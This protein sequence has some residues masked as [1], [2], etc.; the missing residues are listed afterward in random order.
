MKKSIHDINQKIKKGEATIL[1]AEEVTHLVMDGEEPTVE[2]VDVVTTGTCGIMSGTAAIFHLPVAEPGSFKKAR[3]IT[4]NGVSGFPGPCPNEWLGSVDLMVYGT[5]HSITDPQYGGGFLFKDLLHGEEIEIEVE[6]IDGNILKSSATLEDFGTAQM[7]G[8]RFAFKNYTAFI[9]PTSQPVSSI[10]NA[11]DMDGP[12]KGI[13]FSGC[14]ELNP[15]QNDPQLN[16]I[17][18]GTRLLINN[19]EGLFI[20]PGTRSSPEKPNMMITADMKDMDPHYLGGFRTGAGPEVYN[21]VATAIPILDDEIL[22]KTFI[23]NEDI[24]LPVADIRGRHS[25][26]SQT[27]YEVWRNVDE[28]PTYEKELCQNCQICL[29]EERCPTKA[30]QNHDLNQVRCFG[31]G[32]CAYSCP[33][34]TFQMERGHVLMDWEGEIKELEVSCRQSDIKRARELARELK[35]RIERGEFLLNNL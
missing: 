19:S 16:S 29:V 1:T 13:S 31:C 6:D 18:K 9:N 5:S 3:K 25:V 24:P 17:Q 7:I 28:R 33:F 27:T 15:L 12:F 35:N 8:T 26:M 11:V 21:S 34:G 2:D 4:L 14:G 23:K 20:G 30:F 22:R 10:F 32:M